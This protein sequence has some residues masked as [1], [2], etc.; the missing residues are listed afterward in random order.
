MKIRVTGRHGETEQDLIS[1]NRFV[2]I[3]IKQS[4]LHPFA[5]SPLQWHSVT[6]EKDL[7]TNTFI[8]LRIYSVTLARCW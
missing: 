6:T 8:V 3:R 1:P 2:L 5:V 7:W 4:P